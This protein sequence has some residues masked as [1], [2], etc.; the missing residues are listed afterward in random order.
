MKEVRFGKI[1]DETIINN[2][3]DDSDIAPLVVLDTSLVVVY[4]RLLTTN[5]HKQAGG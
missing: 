4:R 2:V 5:F 3:D 1:A